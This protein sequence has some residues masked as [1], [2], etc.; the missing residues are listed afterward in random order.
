MKDSEIE[1]RFAEQDKDFENYV[2]MKIRAVKNNIETVDDDIR[3][4]LRPFFWTNKKPKQAI[5]IFFIFI[6]FCISV[7]S[8]VDLK[9][10]VANK[11]G[12]EL[13]N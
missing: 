11:F 13:K 12:I 7:A 8:S 9:K 1:R 4:E 3:D 5:L 6:L 2:N 10:F